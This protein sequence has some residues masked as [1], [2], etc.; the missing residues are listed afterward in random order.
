[1]S[2]LQAETAILPP[3]AIERVAGD[4]Q[5]LSS[6][7]SFDT[8]WGLGPVQLHGRFWASRG[9]QVVRPGERCEIVRHA[10]L[11]LLLEP[12]SL[13]LFP[14]TT[15]MGTLNWVRPRALFVRLH[16]PRDSGYREEV[17]TDAEGRLLRI[18]RVYGRGGRL[19]RVVLTPDRQAA[20][21]WN[22]APDARAGWRGL[23]QGIPRGQ[24]THAVADGTVYD[25][26]RE[27]RIEPVHARRR[28]PL[29]G[30]GSRRPRRTPHSPAGLGRSPCLC[31]FPR[32]LVGPVWVGAGRT[33]DADETVIGPAV[34]WDDP[35]AR[36]VPE[37]LKWLSLEPSRPAETAEPRDSRWLGRAAKRLFDISFALAALV[38]TLPL[39]PLIM[40]AIWL[41]DGRPFFF[42]HRRESHRRAR[43]PLHQVPLDAQGC[44]D[45]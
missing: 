28:R 19:T 9:V 37:P 25:E 41:E 20:H 26:A 15:L 30:A 36:P 42:A 27:R 10:E 40:L 33:V 6:A 14:L 43:I 23:R 35:S 45:R 22:A 38:L 4:D 24:R 7:P 3:P 5:G 17:V 34:L 2:T 32:R 13:A 21:L 31:R 8:I 39:Y 18:R 29:A 16:D 1:M 12:H 44:R 11:Y